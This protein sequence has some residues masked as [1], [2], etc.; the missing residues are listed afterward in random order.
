MSHG[1]CHSIKPGRV[2]VFADIDNAL[3]DFLL[4]L[5]KGAFGNRISREI[6]QCLSMIETLPL[7]SE[8]GRQIR[9]SR[10]G[11]NI[12]E[13]ATSVIAVGVQQLADVSA[14]MRLRLI[15]RRFMRRTRRETTAK[16][17]GMELSF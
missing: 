14:F 15:G 16:P 10:K 17:D 8:I 6:S 11:V 3:I 4:Q 13:I 7:P 1:G 5:G 9:G 12:R 2:A